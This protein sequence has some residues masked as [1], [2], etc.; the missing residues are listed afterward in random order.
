MEKGIKYSVIIPAFNEESVIEE[1]YRR[2]KSVMDLTQ[3]PYELIFVDDGSQDKTAEILESICKKDR[4]VK[5]ISF[6]R[7]FGHQIAITAGVDNAR[8]EA[9]IVIDA[10]L[11][12]PPEVMLE[13][14]KKWKEGYDVVYGKRIDRKGE[15]FFKLFTAKL[16]YRFLKRITSIDIPVD[17]G[18]F[19]LMDRKVC[20]LINSQKSIKEKNRY[21]R[22]LVSWV[23][24]KQI[25]V[26]YV[27]QPRL[28]GTTK[29]TLKKMLKLA[30]DGIT[31]FSY[32]PLRLPLY[33]GGILLV[34][35]SIYF[36]YAGIQYLM[37]TKFSAWSM[38][39]NIMVFL[40]GMNFIML[41]IIGEYVNRIY[42]EARNRPLYIIKKKIGFEEDEE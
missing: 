27:R 2:I 26:D 21:I 33:L 39:V 20:D 28:S 14:I 3:E 30:L 42:E 8:G 17:T 24:F 18:D 9:V 36:I 38:L 19:R 11:Q 37:F 4:N 16:F 10:D 6:S 13:M 5:L 34:I 41:G 23:G 35:S 12:D 25:G 31:S 40:F 32:F 15:S 22:G 29:Y 7:N 1:S